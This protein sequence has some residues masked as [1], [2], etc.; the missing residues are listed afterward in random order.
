MARFFSE[1]ILRCGSGPRPGHVGGNRRRGSRLGGGS[2]RCLLGCHVARARWAHET[3]WGAQS[4]PRASTCLQRP[5]GRP[6]SPNTLFLCPRET[7][8]SIRRGQ[9][10]RPGRAGTSLEAKCFPPQG[11]EFEE[12]AKLCGVN[13]AGTGPRGVSR[14]VRSPCVWRLGK[15]LL[16]NFPL[17]LTVQ[18]WR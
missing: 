13:P 16:R 14:M 3:G 9:S 8:L 7:S 6:L 17:D 12:L 18:C 4:C 5:P 2:L 1:W 15:K 11:L 10:A